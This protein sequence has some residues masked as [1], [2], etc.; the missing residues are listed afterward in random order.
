VE[1]LE[2]YIQINATKAKTHFGNIEK[3]KKLLIRVVG[4]TWT[5][6]TN[7]TSYEI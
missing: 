2:N 6:L 4:K 3:L 7:W 1:K 5:T